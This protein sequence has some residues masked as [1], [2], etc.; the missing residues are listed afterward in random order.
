[1]ETARKRVPAAWGIVLFLI[2]VTLVFAVIR[3]TNDISNLS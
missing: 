1:M 2:T 3:V